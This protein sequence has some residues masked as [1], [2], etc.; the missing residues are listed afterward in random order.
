MSLTFDEAVKNRRSVYAIEKSSPISKEQVQQIIEQALLHTPS[1]YN[2]QSGRIVL[3]FGSE[4]DSLW[5]IVRDV[6]L[7]LSAPQR[8]SAVLQKLSSFQNGWG[9]VLFF[10]DTDT[11]EGLMSKFP[12]YKENFP[13][14]SLQS[15]GM[16]QY[17]VWTALEA[18]GLGASLQHYN[19]VIDERVKTRWGIPE[20]W[21]L[22][23]QMPFGRPYEKPGEKT[24]LPLE[25]R[26]KVFG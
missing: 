21:K 25:E 23:S 5:D 1:A 13:I 17:V 22:I 24:F 4:H 3:L 16:L 18:R 8:Q 10:E 15:S 20:K 11:V 19:P 14:W 7:P 6:I 12:D 2:S 26:L 9:T